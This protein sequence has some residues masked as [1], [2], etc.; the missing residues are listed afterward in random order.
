[1]RIDRIFRGETGV[2][3]SGAF[4]R[5]RLQSQL[6]VEEFSISSLR[7]PFFY[8]HAVRRSSSSLPVTL[9]E[10]AVGQ[11]GIVCFSFTCRCASFH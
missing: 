11:L 5:G 1:M 8:E 7:G 10:V 4:N 2:I 3:K 9:G 6:F